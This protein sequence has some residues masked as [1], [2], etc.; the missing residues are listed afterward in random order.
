MKKTFIYLLLLLYV[1]VQLKPIT[2]V[3]EDVLAHTFY[4]AQHMATIHFENGKYHLHT[5]LKEIAEQDGS[6]P[7]EKV[8]SNIKTNDTVSS[9]TTPEFIFQLNKQALAFQ[10]LKGRST[11]LPSAF[12]KISNPPPQA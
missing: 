4:K 9:H 11:T 12:L 10:Y 8:P 2:A 3:F 7:S 1:A 5:D 6:S